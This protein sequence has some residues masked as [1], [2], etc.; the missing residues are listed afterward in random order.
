MNT[1]T[2]APIAITDQDRDTALA[3]ITQL[4]SYLPM[5]QDIKAEDRKALSGMGDKNRAF[6]GKVLD[7]ISQNPDFLPRSFDVEKLRQDL[8]S[9]DRLSMIQMRLTQLHDLI[10]ATLISTGSDAYTQALAAYRYA[11]ASDQGASL[12]AMLSEMSQHFA[13]KTKKAKESE[14]TAVQTAALVA[15]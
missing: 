3:L 12:E 2:T 13:K 10:D 14:S 1:S 7:V 5:L 9:F 6:A 15:L 11:K 8:E 4:R